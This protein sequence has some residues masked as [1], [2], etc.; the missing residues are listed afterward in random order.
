MLMSLP[1]EVSKVAPCPV[2]HLRFVDRVARRVRL[3]EEVN[4]APRGSQDSR[5]FFNCSIARPH[6]D[7]YS[8][9]EALRM[10]VVALSEL[11]GSLVYSSTGSRCGRV[12]EVTMAPQED[13][14]RLASLVV[15]TRQGNRL[16]DTSS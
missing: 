1:L 11:L 8:A 15:K 2:P 7:S 9:N 6:C 3:R 10:A 13:P 16:L 4:N 14:A 12:R 5:D